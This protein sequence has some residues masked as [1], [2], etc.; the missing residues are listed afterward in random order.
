VVR[1]SGKFFPGDGKPEKLCLAEITVILVWAAERKRR[2]PLFQSQAEGN[3]KFWHWVTIVIVVF[4]CI[5]VANNVSA[6]GNVVG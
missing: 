3:M 5:W 1:Y 4:V 6:V 2:S